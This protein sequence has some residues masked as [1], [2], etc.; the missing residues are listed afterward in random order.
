MCAGLVGAVEGN[1]ALQKLLRAAGGSS[2][3]KA[4]PWWV[5]N[6]VAQHCL[7]ATTRMWK[8]E[9]TANSSTSAAAAAAKKPPTLMSQT[10]CFQVPSVDAGRILR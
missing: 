3:V 6:L 8:R 1:D 2:H 5:G 4:G 9:L 7:V 10:G